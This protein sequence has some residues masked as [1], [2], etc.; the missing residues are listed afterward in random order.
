MS[1]GISEVEAREIAEYDYKIEH[2]GKNLEYDLTEEQQKIA[3]K[4]T[5]T[6]TR[7]TNTD[8]VWQKKTRKPDDEK[9]TLIDKLF[10]FIKKEIDKQS[11]ISNVERQVDFVVNGNNYSIVLTKHRP[12][13]ER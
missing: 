1:N 4:M 9:R 7:K 12:P 10:N 2:G 13:K 6:G 11:T 8:F 5:T 3:K